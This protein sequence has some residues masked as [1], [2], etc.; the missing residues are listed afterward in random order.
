MPK[1]K[2][3]SCAE[4]ETARRS[5]G[6]LFFGQPLC[7]RTLPQMKQNRHLASRSGRCCSS[8]RSQKEV[9]L[10]NWKEWPVIKDKSCC[11]GASR[12]SPAVKFGPSDPARKEKG[13]KKTHTAQKTS[14]AIPKALGAAAELDCGLRTYHRNCQRSTVDGHQ[15]LNEMESKPPGPGW[16]D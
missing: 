8:L 2:P 6:C 12:L 1:P 3:A 14:Q 15:G 16:V 5:P 11:T 9:A 4:G 7:F 10:S 13:I